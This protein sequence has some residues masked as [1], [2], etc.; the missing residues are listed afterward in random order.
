[1][2]ASGD[3]RAA[4][5][6]SDHRGDGQ[7]RSSLQQPMLEKAQAAI[8]NAARREPALSLLRSRLSKVVDESRL[9]LADTSAKLKYF[10][11]ARQNLPRNSAGETDGDISKIF[12]E[13]TRRS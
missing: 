3:I 1:M 8:A 2:N 4:S 12:L 7:A 5:P 13:T 11:Q 6:R 9:L 10:P